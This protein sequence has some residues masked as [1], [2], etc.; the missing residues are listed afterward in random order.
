MIQINTC[1]NREIKIKKSALYIE[2]DNIIF[3]TSSIEELR[4]FLMIEFYR[5]S[6]INAL[7]SGDWREV[8]PELVVQKRNDIEYKLMDLARI[9]NGKIVVDQL[10]K[11]RKKLC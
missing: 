4:H 3:V 8:D 11:K 7:D 9:R 5:H 1:T 2:L 6:I 10:S